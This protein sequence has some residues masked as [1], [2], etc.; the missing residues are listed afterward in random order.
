VLI[1]LPAVVSSFVRRTSEITE[2]QGL[3]GRER[4]VTVVGPGGCGKTRLTLEAVRDAVVSVHGFVELAPADPQ[5][6][7]ARAVLTGCGG[8][9]EPGRAAEEQLHTRL[10]AAAGLLV[11]DNCEHLRR[12]LGPLVATLLRHCPSLRI[13]ATSRVSL[14]VTGE[15]VLPL[16]GLEPAG[17]AVTLLLDRARHLQ[18]ALSLDSASLGVAREI[19]LLAD[20]LPLTIELAAAHARALPLAD[21]RDGMSDRMSF[22]APGDDVTD[23]SRH[24]SLVSSLDWSADLV[25]EPA[26]RALA[27]LSVVGGRFPLDVA[28]AVTGGNRAALETLVD[29]SLVQFDVSDSSYVLLDTIRE[30]AARELAASGSGDDVHRRL[31]RWAVEF[32]H[33]TREGLERAD[34]AALRRVDARD[35]AVAATLNRAA[36]GGG[37]LPAAAAVAADLAFAWSLRGR[38]VEGLERVQRLAAAIDPPPP[39]LRWAHAFLASYAGDMTGG[40]ALAQTAAEEAAADG[41]HRTRARALTLIGMVLEWADAAA[42]EPIMVE[43][44]ALAD[45]AGDDWCRVEALQVLAYCHLLRDDL[46]AAQQAADAAL[47]ALDRLGH[48]QLRAWDCAI[49]TEIATAQGRFDDAAAMG[50]EGLRA[51]VAIGEPVSATGALRP[52]LGALLATGRIAEAGAL[53]DEHRDFFAQHPG[54]G[55]RESLVMAEAAL[56]AEAE[57]SEAAAT[58]TAAVDAATTVEVT[59]SAA[60]AH[61]LLALARL[62]AGDV[63]GARE[64]ATEAE[65]RAARAGHRSLACRSAL[66]R[67]A[68][69]RVLGQ[70]DPVRT[71]HSALAEAVALGQRPLVLDSLDLM[72]AAAADAA[73]SAD[74]ARL[75]GAVDRLRSD[76]G[77]VPGPLVRL[78]RAAVPPGGPDTARARTEGTALSLDGAVAYASRMRGRRHRPRSGWDSLTPTESEVVALVALGLSNELG[79]ERPGRGS[80][81]RRGHVRALLDRLPLLG[82]A[83]DRRDR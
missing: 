11:L 73:R 49:R 25:G 7:L 17:D 35:A 53:L 24:G 65:R 79:S 76:M 20:G 51:A 62:R 38:C 75:Q 42:A 64:T 56:A 71:A 43:A 27:A 22:L 68:A 59:W 3:I 46:G 34:P 10:G 19:C 72:A 29:H 40:L 31:L 15:A 60:E 14:G 36:T 52:L 5:T 69:E 77:A 23:A 39:A 8:L 81:V 57:P 32:A 50:R 74:A 6:D 61:R 18:P 30:Y 16:A 80:A 41:D 26:R 13:L 66:V 21:I 37:A 2:L 78:L 63:E 67:A 55:V 44:A 48:Q 70:G 45:A 58:A 4:L 47:P 12:Q 28:L 82:R 54:L 83:A 1:A 33:D 9:A